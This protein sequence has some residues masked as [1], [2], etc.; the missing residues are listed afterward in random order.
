MISCLITQLSFYSQ[1]SRSL[2]FLFFRL[3]CTKQHSDHR[4]LNCNLSW[5][6]Y[7]ILY[8]VCHATILCLFI[9]KTIWQAFHGIII[10]VSE[11]IQSSSWLEDTHI[12]DA[13]Y[14]LSDVAPRLTLP[15]KAFCLHCNSGPS[16]SAFSQELLPGK[17]ASPHSTPTL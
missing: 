1:V 14:P 3:R 13:Q 12:T 8:S 15:R 11:Q 2:T 9:E 7:S 17:R 5:V 6:L 4:H 10:S 16:C